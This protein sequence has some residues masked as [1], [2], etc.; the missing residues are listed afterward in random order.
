VGRGTHRRFGVCLRPTTRER[1][2]A[3]HWPIPPGLVPVR[4]SDTCRGGHARRANR[5][6]AP[7]GPKGVRYCTFARRTRASG[8]VL[9][10]PML[11]VGRAGVRTCHKS[12]A[13]SSR[14]NLLES[15]G[16]KVMELRDAR[17]SSETE[18]CAGCG[19]TAIGSTARVYC[20]DCACEH[21]FCARCADD[22]MEAFAA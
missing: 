17:K 21:R 20:P 14:T 8:L 11:R 18:E 5:L 16:G 22:A 9:A 3:A 15:T 1:S 4:V 7:S 13:D 10:S 19:I 12:R 2:V 6:Q